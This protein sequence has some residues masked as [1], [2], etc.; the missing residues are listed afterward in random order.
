M[1][2]AGTARV[3][4]GRACARPD[5]GAPGL[6]VRHPRR[7]GQRV[8]LVNLRF[9]FLIVEA[10]AGPAALGIY[11]VASKYA[12]LLRLPS[13]AVLWV[14]YPHF[15]REDEAA[16]ATDPRA[17]M[18]RVGVSV[19]AG[20]AP[21]ALLAPLVIPFAYGSAFAS[22]VVPACI[23]LVGLAGEGLA[24]VAVGYLYGRGKPGLASAATGAGVVVTIVLDVLLIPHWGVT[25]AAIAS[26]LAY[27]SSTAVAVTLFA[28]RTRDRV[29]V[30]RPLAVQEV[31]ST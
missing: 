24:A 19:A 30:A 17:T 15:A 1:G 3:S 14:L 26:T 9:D 12:E 8:L 11:A 27:L 10:V 31:H 21:L 7:G 18:R 16:A 2:A 5:A 29:R 25:G 23:L 28:R 22:A 4:Q 13:D 6:V 20:A